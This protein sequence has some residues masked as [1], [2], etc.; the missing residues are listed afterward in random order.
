MALAADMRLK[1]GRRRA[2]EASRLL[3]EGC[4][5]L[6]RTLR[7]AQFAA[8]WRS[9][10]RR[11]SNALEG[12]GLAHALTNGVLSPGERR[13]V[14][15]LILGQRPARVL[16]RGGSR[17]PEPLFIAGALHHL[18]GARWFD[19]LFRPDSGRPAARIAA[20]LTSCAE[21]L[22]L[23]R[24]IRYTDGALDNHLADAETEYDL[25]FLGGPEDAYAIYADVATA[26]RHLKPNG[27]IML[28][29]YAP[30]D[31]EMTGQGSLVSGAWRAMSRLRSENRQLTVLPINDLPWRDPSQNGQSRL[32]IA[33]RAEQP[34]RT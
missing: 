27:V 22:G 24:T 10:D 20:A 16:Y 21:N 18:G 9:D 28:H 34:P 19:V 1:A 25:I 26:S 32:A 31:R 23:Q 17:D 30:F 14:Y 2:L 11:I 5:D 15:C 12:V 4:I 3:P 13:A 29:G 7:N 8:Y 6:D 33:A